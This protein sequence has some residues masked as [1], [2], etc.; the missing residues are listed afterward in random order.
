MEMLQTKG[1]EKGELRDIFFG[2]HVCEMG[3][4]CSVLPT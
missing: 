4:N 2:G 3:D 1:Q